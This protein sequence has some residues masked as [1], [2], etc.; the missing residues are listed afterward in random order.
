MSNSILAE[1]RRLIEPEV[2]D[3]G[4]E[5]VEIE[6]VK[7]GLNWYLRIYIDK[8]GGV[9]IDD[10]AEASYKIGEVM[11]KENLITQSYTLEVSSPGIERPLRTRSDFEKYRGELVSL[12][13]LKPIQGY[14]RF[15]GHLK[16]LI[17]NKVILEYENKEIAIP[18]EL[19]EKAHLTFEF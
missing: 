3:L 4:L 12:Y 13:S 16:G 1:V 19:V 11:D 17:D 7:E 18:L 15:T 10:C 14:T 2:R 6:Y 8:E 5:L 9:D